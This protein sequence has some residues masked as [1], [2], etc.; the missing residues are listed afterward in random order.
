ML[1]DWRLR[2]CDYGELNGLPAAELHERRSRY[3][4]RPYPGGESWRQAVHR[5]GRF[6][7]DL[8]L[9][10]AGRRVLV[11][12]HV[13]TRWGLD[14]WISGAR[15]EDL[16]DADFAWSEGWEYRMEEPQDPRDRP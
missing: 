6:L 14:H 16:V 15:L 11:I 3:L 8:S 7:D 1:H 2:E 12:G 13:A 10:W 4:D 5:V 9:R